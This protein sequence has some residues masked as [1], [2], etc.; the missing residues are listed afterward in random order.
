MAEQND[1]PDTAPRMDMTDHE[2]TFSLFMSM[3]KWSSFA[4]GVAVAFLVCAFAL[5]WPIVPTL[6]G[7]LIA[8]PA[9]AWFLR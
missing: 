3:T 2:K 9:I 7:F 6:I 5:D 1:T 4:V 8:S